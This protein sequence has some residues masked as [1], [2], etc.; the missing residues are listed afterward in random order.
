MYKIEISFGHRR[1]TEELLLPMDVAFAEQQALTFFTELFQG[2][3]AYQ[4]LGGYLTDGHVVIEPCTVIWDWLSRWRDT[5]NGCGH[6]LA[7][8][9]HNLS[10]SVS[11]S[12]LP[13]LTA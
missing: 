7:R 12:A 10:R 8:S 6:W 2:G 1:R 11:L 3:Q 4:R 9:P 13:V 5:L